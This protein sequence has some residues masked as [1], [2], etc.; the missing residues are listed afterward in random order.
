MQRINVIGWRGKIWCAL[1]AEEKYDVHWMQRKNI[2]CFLALDAEEMPRR[3]FAGCKTQVGGFSRNNNLLQEMWGR[4][5]SMGEGG[6]GVRRLREC[7]PL[8][9]VPHTGK[10][11]FVKKTI[12]FCQYLA[13]RVWRV[14]M[15]GW[16]CYCVCVTVHGATGLIIL[17]D[18]LLCL[19]VL[20]TN[21]E[22]QTYE[23]NRILRI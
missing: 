5:S 20:T 1:D 12:P 16:E 13:Q 19:A 14:G 17:F 23:W 3:L 10:A 15:L 4:G 11:F 21:R 9:K 6:K 22:A 2:M 18:S 7:I 8:Q